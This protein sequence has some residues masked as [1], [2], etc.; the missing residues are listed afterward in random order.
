VYD[1]TLGGTHAGGCMLALMLRKAADQGGVAPGW[2]L[3]VRLATD[4]CCPI[5]ATGGAGVG[6]SMSMSIIPGVVGA[7]PCPIGP[8]DGVN[9]R[10]AMD[11]TAVGWFC[12]ALI[13]A[14]RTSG[15]RLACSSS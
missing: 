1:N 8:M 9:D 11:T 13:A 4:G 14:S 6:S 15:A 7:S 5:M 12:A 2:R 10:L 3:T